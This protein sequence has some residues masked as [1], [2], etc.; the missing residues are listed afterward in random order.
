MEKHILLT[1]SK[2][3]TEVLEELNALVEGFI[4]L[5]D[6][7]EDLAH[8]LPVVDVVDLLE[9]ANLFFGISR[10]LSFP[11][12]ELRRS[13]PKRYSTKEALLTRLKEL[14]SMDVGEDFE[15]YEKL[16]SP[17]RTV[18]LFGSLLRTMVNG[19]DVSAV[20]T[21]NADAE[22]RAKARIVAWEEA[23]DRVLL[24]DSFLDGVLE[25]EDS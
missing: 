11:C 21:G 14:L 20:A 10:E 12:F 16:S 4:D 3:F 23:Y 25:L 7:G 15:E 6:D 24:Y 19:A 8:D 22:E 13:D 5:Q 9:R 17:E 2:R 1:R 18:Y